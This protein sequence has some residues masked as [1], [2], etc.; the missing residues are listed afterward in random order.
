MAVGEFLRANWPAVAIGVTASAILAVA[1]LLLDTMPPRAIAMATGPKGGAY[2]EIGKRYQVALEGAG[3]QLRLIE[4]AGSAENLA[5]LRDRSS[6]VKVALVQG[7][8]IGKDDAPEFESLGT[9]FYEPLWIFHRSELQGLTPGALRGRKVSIGPEGSGTRALMLELLKRNGLDQQV[10]ELLALAPSAAA[11][12]LLAGEIDVAAFVAQWDAP[13]VQ[14]LIADERVG[15]ANFPRADA[16]VALY[17]FLSKVTVPRGV[18]DLAKDLPPTDVTL[19]APKASLVVRWDLHPAIQDLLLNAAV[20]IHSG[21]GIFHEAGRFPAAEGIDLPL[22]DAAI[23][24]YKSGRPFL[25]NNFPFWIASLLGRLLVL[26][27]PVVAVLYPMIRF[28]P[29]LYAWLMRSKIARLYGE[30]RFL[31]DEITAGGKVDST[32]LARLDQLE[33][34]ANDL[35]MPIV[36]E[37]MM[38]LLRNQIAVVRDRLQ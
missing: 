7:G 20:Q 3:E 4:T 36:Y 11:D 14:R 19:F 35:R 2:Y 6:G 37:S 10:G 8:T 9:L 34:Q 21:P 32:H 24:F 38:Y 29:A 31:E 23:Q 26:L 13:L 17:P 30:L 27:I 33:K 5:L 22:S 18:G 12:K 25:Q 15:L 16:Y 1:I 28:L